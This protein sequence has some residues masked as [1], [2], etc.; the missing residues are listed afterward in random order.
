MRSA[1]SRLSTQ[2]RIA[3]RL[4]GAGGAQDVEP[5][6]V[7]V[8]DLEAEVAGDADHLG[9]GVDDRDV[10]AAREQRLARDLAEAAEADDQHAAVQIL[11]GI[12]ALHRRLLLAAAASAARTRR[13]A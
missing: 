13:A 6:A 10:D 9:V 1:A 4:A 5:G 8:V 12:D 7:A 11:G 2:T 3:L